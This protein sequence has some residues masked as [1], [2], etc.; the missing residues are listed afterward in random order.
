MDR[1]THR[2]CLPP[3]EECRHIGHGTSPGICHSICKICKGRKICILTQCKVKF[4]NRINYNNCYAISRS[5]VGYAI[6]QQNR[7]DSVCKNKYKKCGMKFE[8]LEKRNLTLLFPHTS[9]YIIWNIHSE[10]TSFSRLSASLIV[11][12]TT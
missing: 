1:R 4:D 8:F 2:Y 7:N 12:C 3:T 10:N 6:L 5:V 9:F 11:K